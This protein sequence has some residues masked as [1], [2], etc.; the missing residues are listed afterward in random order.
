MSNTINLN[1]KKLLKAIE[2]L[3]ADSVYSIA[4]DRYFIRGYDYYRQE[5]LKAFQ[6]TGDYSALHA[7]IKGRKQYSV[8]LSLHNNELA[9]SC[10]CPVW[11]PSENCKHVICAIISIKNLF[12]K[13]LFRNPSQNQA[14]REFLSNKLFHQ[15]HNEL[16]QADDIKYSVVLLIEDDYIDIYVQKGKQRLDAASYD[17][18]DELSHLILPSYYSSRSK[19]FHFKRYI[20]DNGNKYP[21][22]LKSGNKTIPL[23][24][25]KNS[26][27][28]CL[29]ELDAS[30][31]YVRVRRVLLHNSIDIKNYFIKDDLLID[32]DNNKISF[33][34]NAGGWQ[35]WDELSHIHLKYR[36][37]DEDDSEFIGDRETHN[38]ISYFEMPLSKFKQ[39]QLVLPSKTMDKT[40]EYLLLK[41]D[42]QEAQIQQTG[43]DYRLTIS[44]EEEQEGFFTIN[45]ERSIND[46]RH[47]P[48]YRTFRL[49][50]AMDHDLSGPLRAK[51]RKFFIYRAFFEMLSAKTITAQNKAI[52][53]ALA[54]GDFNKPNM[55]RTVRAYLKA[56]LSAFLA[57]EQ[58]LQHHAGDWTL[59][60][61]NKKKELP[62]FKIPYDLFGW[63]IFK[64]SMM[65]DEMYVPSKTLLEGLP[66][67]HEKCE[68]QG[69]ELF[70]KN[71]PV[72]IASWDFSFDASRSSGID[73]F[74]ISPEI[75]CNGQAIDKA[76]WNKML[77][78]KSLLEGK[79]NIQIMDSNALR[80]FKLISTIYNT[81][82]AA[83]TGAK[84]KEVVTVPRLRILDW[85]E[86]RKNGVNI[87][88]PPDDEIIIERLEQF[89]K[90]ETRALPKKLKATLRPYQKEGSYWLSFLYEH[91]FGACLADD[92]GLG[93]TIQAITLLA[94]IHEGIV[95]CHANDKLRPHLIAV[96]P[97]LL[98]NWE[99]E[100][101]KFYPEFKIYSYTGNERSLDFTGYDIILTT[102]ALI[103]RDIEKLKEIRFNVIIFDE[104]QAIKNIYADTTGAVRQLNAC[105]RL[106]M[107]GTPLENHLG[108]Y[109]SIIDLVLPGLLG[110]YENFKPLIKRETSEELDL[111]IKR[112]RPFVLRRTK[113]KIL[114]EL[115]AKIETDVYLELT[116]KQKGLYKKTVEQVKSTINAAYL[117]R[118]TGQANII[119]LTAI[120]KLRQLC[121][122]PRLL[123]P[124]IKEPSPKID[125]LINKLIELRDEGHSALVFSQFTSFLDLLEEDLEKHN[126]KFLRLDG[127]TPVKKRKKLVETFQ[128][129]KGPSLF[130]LSLKAGGQGLNLTKASYV[131]H[132]D[133]WWNPAVENQASDRAHRIGQKKK[134]TVTRILTHHTIEEKMM[135]LKKKKLALYNAVMDETGKGAKSLSVSKADFNFLLGED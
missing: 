115:P 5:R 87:K 62:L 52:R 61:I 40:P 133:P 67:L 2:T 111:I 80:I 48:S 22:T 6:W 47:A 82:S 123:S 23:N 50:T 107:T 108:E 94:N 112:T 129:D 25:E 135:H 85:I 44:T 46:S 98:F 79:D 78:Q 63:E 42:G 55:K 127:S 76:L 81:G 83:N 106:A 24:F 122:S 88:L 60:A 126:F 86:L 27:Y 73:W 93:K 56:H 7:I 1:Q 84:G 119:A 69:I 102:Y 64:D 77:K 11:H 110:K 117:K 16:Q 14:N 38:S 45:A 57:E 15:A 97:S 132:L 125:F 113:E 31:D 8:T 134:V 19:L 18:P 114:K 71:K 74:E 39:L 20:F 100:L 118:T 58:Y 9:Y 99:S 37:I 91:R 26:D 17:E 35:I 68:E 32:R 72:V 36:D 101:T 28:A 128:S 13:V 95:K 53:D 12:H 49:L 103:R 66:V 109:Y 33:I 75:R 34:K 41:K 89:E 3:P 96:P 54:E 30:N 65:H 70:L 121:I 4:P 124:D 105:F 116:A 43:Q 104:A 29:T 90:I 120:L 130:L 10:D 131:F 21:I 51:K 92:M 59:S